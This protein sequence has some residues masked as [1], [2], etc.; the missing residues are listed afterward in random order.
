MSRKSFSLGDSRCEFQWINYLKIAD[1]IEM[2]FS[3]EGRSVKI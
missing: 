3:I 2:K 1:F